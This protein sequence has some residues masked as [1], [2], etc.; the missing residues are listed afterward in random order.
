ML[1]NDTYRRHYVPLNT[2]GHRKHRC[3]NNVHIYPQGKKLKQTKTTSAISQGWANIVGTKFQ[4]KP[5]EFM[6]HI[7]NEVKF[8]WKFNLRILDSIMLSAE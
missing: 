6:K 7:W 1:D 4:Q 8:A 2:L 3:H 5:P